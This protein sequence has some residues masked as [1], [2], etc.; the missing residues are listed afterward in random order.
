MLQQRS[1]LG[2]S[3]TVKER[4]SGSALLALFREHM[5]R[6]LVR[7]RPRSRRR[8]ETR[9][10]AESL[11]SRILLFV[12]GSRWSRTAT[13]GSGLGQGDATTVTWSIVPDGTAVP[14]MGG[15]SG[16]SSDP[17]NLVSFLSSIYGTVTADTNFTDEV[18][19]QHF[20][21]TFD[22]WSDCL[23]YTSP[24]PRD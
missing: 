6:G 14:A 21:S 13:D 11:E 1:T 23:L 2:D 24:S 12:V 10:S 17:S 16:E 22:R 18:W 8:Y 20:E 5:Q 9:V 4:S 3:A 19:F 7:L 15:I